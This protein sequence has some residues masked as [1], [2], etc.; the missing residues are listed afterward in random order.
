MGKDAAYLRRNKE[1]ISQQLHAVAVE[2]LAG[3]GKKQL[4]RKKKTVDEP[5]ELDDEEEEGEDEGTAWEDDDE[6]EA[7]SPIKYSA[8]TK[9]TNKTKTAGKTSSKT[10]VVVKAKVVEKRKSTGKTP[11]KKS[12]KT[13]GKEAREAASTSKRNTAAKKRQDQANDD[14][15]AGKKAKDAA[16]KHLEDKKQEKAEDKRVGKKRVADAV[17]QWSS[18]IR[19]RSAGPVP[20]L[21]VKAKMSAAWKGLYNMF[22]ACDYDDEMMFDEVL[23]EIDRDETCSASSDDESLVVAD[24]A[25]EEP[26]SEWPVLQRDAL[27]GFVKDESALAKMRKSGWQIDTERFPEDQRYPGLY[28]AQESTRYHEQHLV[29]RADKM[30]EK[31][32]VPG[33]K[34]KEQFM[35]Q[36]SKHPDIKP[37]EI[38]I[39]LGLLIARMVNPQRRHFYDHWATTAAGAVSPETF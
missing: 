14:Q 29:G 26:Q 17:D 9:T 6:F 36:E 12:S 33:K 5:W 20:M 32:K 7:L 10:K 35:E 38:V 34:T 22:Y 2:M 37:H 31:Q 39:L 3:S 13:L 18:R 8:Q 4:Q 25:D 16:R 19:P 21:R 30:F 11:R 23:E 24:D 15:Q 28:N 1:L 27:I